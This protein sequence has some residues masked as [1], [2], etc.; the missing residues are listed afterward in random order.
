[1]RQ[2][3]HCTI[4]RDLTEPFQA[5]RIERH[6]FGKELGHGEVDAFVGELDERFLKTL[7]HFRTKIQLL[8]RSRIV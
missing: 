1:M 2:L 8:S 7:N 5:K 6:W 4:A 3:K